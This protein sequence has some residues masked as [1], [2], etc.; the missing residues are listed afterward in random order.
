MRCR[1]RTQVGACGTLGTSSS[2]QVDYTETWEDTK[3]NIMQIA[4]ATLWNLQKDVE[5][6]EWKFKPSNK[7]NTEA[8]AKVYDFNQRTMQAL[9][10]LAFVHATFEHVGANWEVEISE[11]D[12]LFP[13]VPAAMGTSC[14]SSNST[15]NDCKVN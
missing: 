9:N 15:R 8:N 5:R 7:N 12:L 3:E 1:R 4:P 13:D 10:H 14:R 11:G 2:G 6:Q